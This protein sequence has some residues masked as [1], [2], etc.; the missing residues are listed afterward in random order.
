MPE[1]NKAGHIFD[2]DPNPTP[3]PTPTPADLKSIAV[4]WN[5]TE[6]GDTGTI[7]LTRVPGGYRDLIRRYRVLVDG[8]TAGWIGRGDT[9]R[10]EA[11]VGGHE[12][13]L[14]IDWC[15]STPQWI[16]VLPASECHLA[17]APGGDGSQALVAVTV[18]SNQ[19][20]QLWPVSSPADIPMA[21]PDSQTRLIIAVGMTAI[22]G[23]FAAIVN[24][25]WQTI[26]TPP[27]FITLLGDIGIAAVFAAAV[28]FWISTRRRGPSWRRRR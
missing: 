25:V 28:V 21:K 12:V 5:G 17:C 23:V 3:T 4:H 18:G 9:V 7:V 16:A 26:A 24:A 27:E 10:I 19:Y 13:Q 20:I 1:P 8:V 11:P 22:G 15:S 2:G 6:L 14:K